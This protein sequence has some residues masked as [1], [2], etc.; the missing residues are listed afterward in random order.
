MSLSIQPSAISRQ[1]LARLH[2]TAYFIQKH[3]LRYGQAARTVAP[4]VAHKHLK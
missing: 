3:R 4:F 1:P 2:R